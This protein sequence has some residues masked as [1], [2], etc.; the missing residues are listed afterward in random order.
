M[1]WIT[2][3]INWNNFDYFNYEDLNRIENN[4]K[5]IADLIARYTTRP[6]QT[7]VTN[8][9]IKTIEFASSFNRI[10][11]NIQQLGNYY[12]PYEWITPKTNWKE[13]DVF[14]YEDANRLERNLLSLYQYFSKYYSILA[15]EQTAKEVNLNA[16]HKDDLEE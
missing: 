14:S 4:T 8:R 15:D 10:E 16:L 1:A 11:G 3:K 9:T 13:N 6:T 5:E 7:Y 12:K 2:P